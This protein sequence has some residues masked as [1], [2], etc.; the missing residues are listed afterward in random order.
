ATFLP[1]DIHIDSLPP[2]SAYLVEAPVITASQTGN[3]YI[4]WRDVRNGNY[5][6]W[7][8]RSSDF[9]V[10]FAGDQRIDHGPTGIHTDLVHLASDKSNH[11]YGIWTYA[12]PGPYINVSKLWLN[13][14]SDGG[15]TWTAADT[16]IDSAPS[17]TVAHY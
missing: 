17:T 6:A 15:A 10:S 5:Q 2:G 13:H 4:A 3:V 1:A 8:N 16:R 14:S 12:A 11:V 9:G 7:F